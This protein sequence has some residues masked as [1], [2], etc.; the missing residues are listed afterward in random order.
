MTHT[1]HSSSS[2]NHSSQ[3]SSQSSIAA[4]VPS[5]A[6]V[7]SPTQLPDL[8]LHILDSSD[9]CIK[10]LDLDG[11]ILFISQGGQALLG[12]QDLTLFLNTSWADFWQ[13]ADR[14][15]AIEA[16]TKARTGE[17][18]TFQ[19]HRLML[20]GES[21]WWDSKISP[22]RGADGQIERLLCISRDITE[23]KRIEDERKRAEAERQHIEQER[24]R[25][26]GVG[27][28]L[29]VIAGNDG[30]FRWVS[31][32]FERLLGW[33]TAE[34]TTRP[35][36]EFVHPDDIPASKQETA[37]LFSGHET[38]EFENRYRHK[39]GSYRWLLWNAKPYPAE[40]I[41]YGTA[42]D[43]TERKQAEIALR[44]SE[45]RFRSLTA[46][47]PQ[48]IWTTTPDGS[49][50]YLSQQWADYIGLPPEQLY[51]WHWQDVVHPE[52][53]PN[54]LR[55][56]AYS[57]QTSEPLQIKHR[58]RC[59][60]GE[61]RWQL[62]RGTPIV[63]EAGQVTKWVG[64]CTDIQTEIDAQ[65][66]LRQSEAR[67]R[68]VTANLP[69]A[70]VF[71]VDRELRYQL[72]EGK[73][74]KSA[75]F[76][77]QDLVGKT[78]WEALD[79]SL[80]A[81]YEPHF[82]RALEGEPFSWEHHSHNRHYI[83][84]GVPLAIDRGEVD[85]VLIVSYDITERVR[86][87]DERKY[88]EI[89]LRESEAFNRSVVDSSAD[90]IKVLDLNGCLLTLNQPGQ[91][92]LEIEDCT[93]L[94][95]TPWVKFW[96][97]PN[98]TKATEAMHT[99]VAGGV[100][101]FS[102]YC[103]TMKGTPKWWDVVITPILDIA[104]KPKELLVVSRDITDRRQ[105]EVLLQATNER[106]QLL[107][108]TTSE[109]LLQE[110]PQSFLDTLFQKLSAHLN[111]EIYVHYL[112]Q[113]E[114][115]LR[116]IAHGGIS[117][118]IATAAEFLDL[119]QA[120]CGYVVQHQEAVVLENALES[121][122]PLAIPVQAIGIRAYASHP[123]I[124]NNRAIGTLGFGTRNHDRF[125]PDELDLMQTVCA[126]VSTA[127]Q[128]SQL[129]KALQ[130]RAEELAQVNR[131]KD[132]FLA[133][134][135]HELRTPLNPI[136]GWTQLLRSGRLNADKTAQAIETI[137]R[138]AKLQVQLIEDLLD[139]SRV[140]RGKLS[141]C[142]APVNLDQ[143][144]LAALETVRLSAE[145]KSLHFQTTLTSITRP[146]NGDA[147]RLQ[148]VVWNLLSNAVK[149]TPEGGQITITLTQTGAAAQIQVSD[150]G[151]GIH[152][153]FLPYVFEHFRQEN[154]TTT[155]KFGGLGLGLAIARQIVELHG[156][157]IAATS[158]GEGQG[159]T[160]TVKLP[161]I[162]TENSRLRTED[163]PLNPQ[164]S[165]L[166]TPLAGLQILVVDDET[167]TRDLMAFVLKQ[168]GAIVTAV[169]SPFA[170]IECLTQSEFD[171]LVSDIGMP[172]MDGYALM[173]QIRQRSQTIPAR[174][175][176]LPAI[177]LTAYAGEG[178]QQQALQAG[179]QQ[180]IA[181]PVEPDAIVQ[182]IAKLCGR[183]QEG[184]KS[185]GSF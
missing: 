69:N 73:A 151:K 121:T 56:W 30:Y 136:L 109:L 185:A 131:I 114:Q 18:S 20:S 78:I 65:Q 97:E 80:A 129:I 123:L 14:Q 32:T 49:V 46:T 163:H 150:T 111:L 57:L 183:D 179:F 149:F 147:G 168:A 40:Q 68:A 142:V 35:W 52:D 1:L 125:T 141:L 108:E 178:D 67:L 113:D 180:H 12:S 71:I 36:T 103:P 31:P 116:L 166:K 61:W 160:F 87:E 85:A 44:Q 117:A 86:A 29:Q 174:A 27:S 122:S 48:L 62:V 107:S 95:G 157:T 161:L 81:T 104:G 58:F 112:L 38:V 98:R 16:I 120:V 156:G 146:V 167:D 42:V 100:G 34:I 101:R 23:R 164:P 70:A 135:S 181:K 21:R 53:L 176:L 143:V 99:A 17:V 72:A 64:T 7:T 177:A 5:T 4:G 60:T 3:N 13:G 138:N 124:V 76:A 88:T 137:E 184:N 43:I 126:Q 26:L 105:S 106:L 50:D 19:A 145:A 119:G 94:I 170:A 45:E 74:L 139:I 66:A 132:E 63:D 15:A 11:R 152:P 8:A 22:M 153:D 39:D 82:R 173:C 169:S 127:L 75:G 115:R 84:H 83:S 134:L 96:Q 155:R 41:I 2:G 148:Q 89:A 128:R 51:D 47:I 110:D 165:A 10:V 92:L 6:E 162:K 79:P 102:G 171:A 130:Q 175:S 25:F 182:A 37:S 55:D 59:H 24:D 77:A 90:C 158:A 9:D 144:I 159:A 154:S 118:E 28:D 93:P 133:V 91:C 33:T 54:T 140:L 172:E